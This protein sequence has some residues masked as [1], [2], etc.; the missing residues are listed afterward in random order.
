MGSQ[1][2]MLVEQEIKQN[3]YNGEVK[4]HPE[5][6]KKKNGRPPAENKTLSVIIRCHKQ[7]RLP[8]L[9]EAI[10]SLS[11]QE[12]T[13]LEVVVVIQNGTNDFV[14]DVQEIILHQ[15]WQKE[16]K[17]KIHT[18]E[19]QP[20]TDGRSTLLNY[21]IT[22]STGRYLAFLDDDDV[23]YQH[24]YTTLIHKLMEE[25]GA[26][27][28]VGGCRIAKTSQKS[29]H[30]YIS[31]KETPFTAGRNRYDLFRDN[32]IPIHSYVIDREV[33]S[34]SDLY[35]DDEMPPL[36]DYDFLLRLGSKYEF[37]FSK[38]DTFVCE[39][40]IHNSNSLPYTSDATQE[41]IAKHQR[42]YQLIEEKKKN[43]LCLIPL[44]DLIEIRK[45]ETQQET[46]IE[47]FQAPFSENPQIFRK[48]LVLLGDNVYH[49]FKAYP[50]VEKR[51]SKVV[52]YGWKIYQQKNT[53]SS[54][55]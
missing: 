12:W 31:T 41:Q 36:E 45:Q 30:W 18:I 14:R 42:A 46:R 40:R 20:G 16:P 27:I 33:V 49:F 8:F 48:I 39:Y 13:D 5:T 29:N 47:E 32:F 24:G 3:G 54:D 19:F 34:A 15:P 4:L 21:G 44:Q 43:L 38:L 52:H 22:H 9:E 6:N 7:E 17:I 50:Q 10:F 11:I 1:R 55:E 51:L 53:S 23:V 26:A 37:D 28:A 35:F 2:G 25:R